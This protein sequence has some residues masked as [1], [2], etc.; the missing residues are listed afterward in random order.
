MLKGV[1]RTSLSF[2]NVTPQGRILTRF[3]TDTD[4]V[5]SVLPILIVDNIYLCF[6]FFATIYV[7]SYSV[8]IFTTV[9]V[10]VLVVYYI[11][12]RF[13]MATT[14]QL[15]R[16]ESISVAPVL[17]YFGESVTGVSTIKAYELQNYFIMKFNEKIDY[18]QACYYPNIIAS[19]WLAVRLQL[20]GAL[21]IL[22]TALFAVVSRNV[23]DPGLVGLSVTYALE[24]YTF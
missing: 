15:K 7:I 2:F 20:I 19:C 13:Y 18:N 4:I 14:R 1:M 21:I 8:P 22:C 6:C 23:M 10:P 5:D 24:V 9:V 17:S 11:I 12:Q 16:M 3:S